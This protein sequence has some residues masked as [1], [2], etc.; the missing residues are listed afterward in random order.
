MNAS[1]MIGIL[2]FAVPTV[3][4]IPPSLPGGGGLACVDRV[5]N[6]IDYL[7]YCASEIYASCLFRNC[8]FTCQ[9][10]NT[11]V[12]GAGID[13]VGAT[14]FADVGFSRRGADGGGVFTTLPR[15]A[16]MAATT[17]AMRQLG[18]VRARRRLLIR[19]LIATSL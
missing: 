2:G 13:D 18:A 16:P 19:R 3:P 15:P 4:P 6:C 17:T 11:E 12:A 8:R 5:L 9:Y 7:E 10:C 1:V 14:A